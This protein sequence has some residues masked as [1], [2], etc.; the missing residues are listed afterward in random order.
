ME[1]SCGDNKHHRRLSSGWVQHSQREIQI[2]FGSNIIQE[3]EDL[4]VNGIEAC[5][6]SKKHPTMIPKEYCT[7]SFKNEKLC[8][9]HIHFPLL[10]EA[11][12]TQRN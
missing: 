12:I 1:T 11:L 9:S 4:E 3:N 2:S 5:K 8:H 10:A 7:K 6:A